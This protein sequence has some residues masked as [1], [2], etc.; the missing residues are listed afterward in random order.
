MM[1]ESG[2]PSSSRLQLE[3]A[4]DGGPGD[5][6]LGADLGHGVG[7]ATVGAQFLVHVRAILAWR[8]VSLGFCPLGVGVLV[9]CRN[10]SVANPHWQA[11]S[12]NRGWRYIGPYTGSVTRLTWENAS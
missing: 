10:P 7:P 12:T 2:R 5:P 4:I 3:V 11:V 9:D 1:A 6:E 8:G